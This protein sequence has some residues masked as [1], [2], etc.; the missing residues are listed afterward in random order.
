MLE[1]VVSNDPEYGNGRDIYER[2]VR[3]NLERFP[4]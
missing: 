2:F 1:A 3:P 4:E